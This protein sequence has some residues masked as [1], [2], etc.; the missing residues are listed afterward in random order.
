[1]EQKSN[2]Q[3]LIDDVSTGRLTRRQFVARGL[4]AGLSMGAVGSLLAGCGRDD[5]GGSTTTAG[6]TA[7]TGGAKAMGGA[8]KIGQST[9]VQSLDPAFALGPADLSVASCV[10][11]GLVAFRPG[12]YELENVLAEEFTPSDDGLTIHFKLKPGIA[13]HG[14]YGELTAEDV[15]YTFERVAGLTEPAIESPYVGDWSPYLKEVRVLGPLEGEIVLNTLFSPLYR[16]TLPL[17]S[18]LVLCKKALEERGDEFATKPIGTGPY[19]VVEFTPDQQVVVKPFEGYSG[20]GAP[21][22]FEEIAFIATTDAAAVQASLSSGDLDIA[23]IEPAQVERLKTTEG[24]IVDEF[25]SLGFVWIAVNLTHPALKDVR[26]RQ[27]LRLAVDVPAVLATAYEGVAEQASSI[28]APVTGIGV[29]ADAPK[30]DRDVDAAKALLKEAGSEGLELELTVLSSGIYPTI[31]QLVQASLGEA[32]VTVRINPQDDATYWSADA[33]ELARRQLTLVEFGGLPDPYFQMQWFTSDQI[34]T[35][36]M[37]N[38][39]NA[40]FDRLHIE[41]AQTSGDEARTAK[42]VEMARLMDESAA[43]IWLVWPPRIWA[44]R[45]L[46]NPAFTPYGEVAVRGFASA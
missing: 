43:M 26:V 19:E 40:D 28:I 39:S 25:S 35:Y 31:A 33:A 11:E 16:T 38:W 9:P 44:H 15:K 7:T 14:G 18:G 6:G 8:I 22:Q 13:F 10:F 3:R 34:G 46:L 36:N 1:M 30:Y 32:G 27:A 2:P 41:A 37:Q 17:L 29:W 5:D 12:S 42:Y 20:A 24:L 23:M 45:T 4:A 21:A